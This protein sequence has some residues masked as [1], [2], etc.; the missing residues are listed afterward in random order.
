MHEQAAISSPQTQPAAQPASLLQQELPAGEEVMPIYLPVQFKLSVGAPDDPLEDE[1]DAMAGKVMRMPGDSFVQRKCSHCEAEAEKT[2]GDKEE[3]KVQRR[4]LASFI[5]PFIQTKSNGEGTVSDTLSNQISSSR[6]SG[7]TIDGETKT[8][9]E[10]RFGTDFSGVKIHTGNESVQ[11]NRELNAKAFTVGSDIYFNEG[12]YNP[13][14]ES[15]KHLLAHELT[16]T[17]QQD[18]GVGVQQKHNPAPGKIIQRFIPDDEKL[19]TRTKEENVVD[20]NIG[21][22]EIYEMSAILP[23]R[24][25]TPETS[26][27]SYSNRTFRAQKLMRDANIALNNKKI[28]V[29]GILGP[30]MLIFLHFIATDQKQDALKF[31]VAGLGFDM[32]A[33][34]SKKA[35]I[36]VHKSFTNIFK[37]NFVQEWDVTGP[38]DMVFEHITVSDEKASIK[39][40]DSILFEDAIPQQLVDD[41]FTLG[42]RYA[43]LKKIYAGVSFKGRAAFVTANREFLDNSADN[44]TMVNRDPGKT[45]DNPLRVAFSADNDGKATNMDSWFGFQYPNA[46]AKST[47]QQLGLKDLQG[48]PQLTGLL[49]S[50]YIPPITTM[51]RARIDVIRQQYLDDWM[52]NMDEYIAIKEA[53]IIAI[54]N[55]EDTSWYIIP[56]K[57]NHELA[58]FWN[59][60]IVFEKLL[61]KLVSHPDK[62][63]FTLMV[64]RLKGWK[65]IDVLQ[66]FVQ[67]CNKT[68]YK[69]NA[70]VVEA[71]D[72]LQKMKHSVQMH[73][74]ATGSKEEQGVW[75]NK[76]KNASSFLHVGDVTGG[77]Y[78]ITETKERLKNEKRA[79]LEA[80]MWELVNAKIANGLSD[81]P[82]PQKEMTE[83]ELMESVLEQAAKEVGITQSDIEEVKYEEAFRIKGVTSKNISGVEEFFV[84]YERVAR[85]GGEAG[86]WEVTESSGGYES[87]ESFETALGWYHFHNTM[88]ATEKFITYMAVGELVIVGG[89]VLLAGGGAALIALGG[90]AKIVGL[91]IG[92]SVLIYMITTDHYTVEG[93]LKAALEGY[94]MAVGFKL[95][96]PVGAAAAKLIGTATFRQKLVGLI[97]QSIITGGGTGAFTGAGAMFIEDIITGQLRSPEEYFKKAATG[98]IYGALFELG[99]SFVIGPIFRTVGKDVL[100]KIKNIEQLQSFFTAKNIVLKPGEWGTEI[101]KAYSGFKKWVGE[102][103]QGKAVGEIGREMLD[104]SKALLNSY[105]TGLELTI[106]RQ[107][108][109]LID[110]GMTKESGQALEN[111]IASSRAKLGFLKSNAF[112]DDVLNQLVKE[113]A[114]TNPFFSVVNAADNALLEM[115]MQGKKLNELA[116]SPSLL[117]VATTR[118]PV[119]VAGLLK[120]RFDANVPESEA[121]A[122]SLLKQG[123]DV[124]KKILDLLESRGAAVTPKSLLRI[125][126]SGTVL[127]EEVVEGVSRMLT[128]AKPKGILAADIENVLAGVSNDK[129]KAF[130]ESMGKLP[131]NEF[132]ELLGL[133]GKADQAVRL[134]NYAKD[135][136]Q[137]IRM[138]DLSGKNANALDGIFQATA[139]KGNF[140]DDIEYLLGKPGASATSVTDLVTLFHGDAGLARRV[141]DKVGPLI[142]NKSLLDKMFS[143]ISKAGEQGTLLAER[144]GAGRFES[145]DGYLDLIKKSSIDT[146][147]IRGVNQT[148]DKAEALSGR[149]VKNSDLRFEDDGGGSGFHDVDIGVKDP[150]VSGGYTE[151]YQFKSLNGPVTAKKIQDA[152]IQMKNVKSA[153]KILEFKCDA[154][155]TTAI[156]ED[157]KVLGEMRFQSGL[158]TAGKGNGI[159]EFRFIL[160][161]GTV[162]IK[163]TGNL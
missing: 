40:C 17:I 29:D 113:P 129:I 158:K 147:N 116:N 56:G 75:I 5:T 65:K 61:D 137:L 1:A 94:L 52:T 15:G 66:T 145:V 3:E 162:I 151:A 156:I 7:S 88:K 144:L 32:E 18:G 12:Q 51:E 152:A 62:N 70:L 36:A 117:K 20:K 136:A 131:K 159:T 93:F 77:M 100:N 57:M 50:F 157:A 41:G 35:D 71:F 86:Q 134:I 90:G 110:A 89:I 44:T 55:D 87:R 53:A 142:K 103:F 140:A 79:A 92:I 28:G 46:K 83:K 69:T 118:K 58:S 107:A 26:P 14:S 95:I 112:I 38:G 161:D 47:R 74:Y 4:P 67:L 19:L 125:A 153:K 119:E 6:G 45:T 82:K 31:Q 9:M 96:A 37:L 115:L 13:G 111:L 105:V 42:Q 21:Y 124:Q 16:H 39:W 60:P 122:S 120:N 148:I 64:Q 101:G 59:K 25:I 27:Y 102:S 99:G 73:D 72:L 11:M 33:L 132:D 68:K 160:E 130:L 10:N 8:F 123:D 80:R 22:W 106:H 24:N 34:A 48:I 84:A 121:W 126:E 138:L 23:L 85:V 128:E 108:L 49:L 163:N 127:S 91:S 104:K 135:S 150:A 149:G 43:I 133:S 143:T 76:E 97:V 109:D 155:T 2:S 81:T 54:L 98:A 146:Q 114:R 154:S 139:G 78:R 30:E 141:L 63:Y